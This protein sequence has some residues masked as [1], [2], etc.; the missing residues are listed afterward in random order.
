MADQPVPIVPTPDDAVPVDGDAPF[1]VVRRGYDRDQVLRRLR[2]LG[3]RIRDLESG[4]EVG[5]IRLPDAPAP[6]EDAPPAD[7]LVGVAEHIREL[8]EAFDREIDRQRRKAELEATVVVAEARTEAAQMRLDARAAE[9]QALAEAE[10][11]LTVAREDAETLRRDALALRES[12]LIDLREIRD[13]M[14]TSLFELESGLPEDVDAGRVVVL[15]DS[16]SA[17]SADPNGPAP[18]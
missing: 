11:L 16:R 6:L 1:D 18:A 14:R 17:S 7:P 3:D 13:R 12:T 5:E 4:M 15:E 10:R 8:V 2:E 9:E